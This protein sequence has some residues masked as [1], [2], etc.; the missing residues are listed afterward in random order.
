LGECV[1]HST[2]YSSLISPILRKVYHRTKGWVGLQ[3]TEILFLEYLKG[4]TQEKCGNVFLVIRRSQ[5]GNTVDVLIIQ[6]GI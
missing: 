2:L 3:G 1:P 6:L 5:V 4:N